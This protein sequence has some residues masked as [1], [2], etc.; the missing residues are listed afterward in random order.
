MYKGPEVG[1]N[2]VLEQACQTHAGHAPPVWHAYV[3]ESKENP[4][5]SGI[6]TLS[7]ILQ[8]PHKEFRVQ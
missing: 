6:T 4:K 8:E 2:E 3:I 1:K 7:E 5:C